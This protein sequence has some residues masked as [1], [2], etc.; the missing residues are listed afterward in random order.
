MKWI[1]M[2]R[3]RSS[4]E[5]LEEIMPSLKSDIDLINASETHAEAL[6][7]Q[8][9]LYSGDLSLVVVWKNEQ[10]PGKTR[11]GMMFTERLQQM[12]TVDHAVWIPTITAS[13]VIRS[14]M[15]Y[16]TSAPC[17]KK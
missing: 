6:I 15:N 13:N 12:G 4:I 2:I 5:A 11:Q 7:L 3:V 17:Q 1:E 10:A 14:S 16:K 9:A 8:H